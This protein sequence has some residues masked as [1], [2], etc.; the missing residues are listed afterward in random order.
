MMFDWNPDKYEANFR[1]H[2]VSFEE[3]QEAFYDPRR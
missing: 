1:D 3:A 2:K